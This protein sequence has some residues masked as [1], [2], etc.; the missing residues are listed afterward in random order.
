MIP[1]TFLTPL[2]TDK[3][4]L[5]FHK[6]AMFV[7]DTNE[8]IFL[9]GKAGSGKTTFL[10]YIRSQTKKR[11]AIVAP[12]G[13]AAINAGGETIHSF[14]QLPFGPYV[15]GNAG[16]FGSQTGGVED[17]HSLLARLRFRDTK[18][19]LLRKLELLIIDEISMVRA[20][21]LDAMDLVLRHVRRKNHLPFGGVQVVFIGDMF[22][23]P[24]VVLPDEWEILKAYY[25]GTY[26]F[27]SQVIRQNPPLYIELS[28]V[29][30]QKDIVF[31]DLLNRIRTGNVTHED[32]DTLNARY[33]DD[34]SNYKGYIVLCTHNHLADTIN[35]QE[36]DKLNT[37]IH[38]FT[39]K[40]TNEFN[41]KNL[42]TEMELNLREGAQVMFI[43]NDLQTPRR[44]FNGKIGVIDRISAD[45][46][47]VSFPSDPKSLPVT[48]DLE[49][50]KNVRYVLD[51]K[52]GEIIEDELGSFAQ[53][54][55]RLAWAITVHKSQG[56]TLEKAIV[57]LNRAFAS[58]QVY[59]A[60]SRCTSMEGLALR[61]RLNIENVMVDSRIIDFA[62]TETADAELDDRLEISKRHAYLTKLI[63]ACSFTEL[64]T[65]LEQWS[66]DLFKI[67]IGPVK[68][69]AELIQKT[70]DAIKQAQKHA[71]TF[72]WQVQEF[73][74]AGQD[75]KTYERGIAAAQYFS[76]KVL[77][78]V[79]A[80][81]DAHLI[82][83]GGQ[84]K[85]AKQEKLWKTIRITIDQK[86]AELLKIIPA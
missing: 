67:K 50:W 68:E 52:K 56:L 83:L 86:K 14:L 32:I 15:P 36:L 62:E 9:T 28:K 65:A 42:P 12:T 39:G 59:V 37:P 46:I 1:A 43:K 49:V 74:N 38:K 77:T 45:G 48:V 70:I 19:Q 64:L 6:A 81:I 10:K 55:L 21:V 3:D 61:S 57:D 23:L 7:C 47:K 40:I 16:G 34:A 13:I 72:H 24:P 29:Y 76:A 51:A 73:F 63:Q 75:V 66:V 2:D 44:Y 82:I 54:P 58:G 33:I 30:R 78:P 8:N 85:V 25:P 22:Q 84:T 71:E 5:P 17:K 79:L 80:D 20:D 41:I 35:K 4:N 31:I 26:F 27:D 69:N 60:L 18:L 11:S 53:Y